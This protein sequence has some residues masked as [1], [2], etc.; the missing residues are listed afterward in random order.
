MSCGGPHLAV[1]F[2]FCGKRS[3]DPDDSAAA[4]NAKVPPRVHS[5]RPGDRDEEVTP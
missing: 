1:D 5:V 4:L 3:L 2:E